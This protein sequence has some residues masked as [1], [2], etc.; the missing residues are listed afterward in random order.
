LA[1][2][3]KQDWRSRSQ[4]R[5][6]R[7]LS[8][9]LPFF[10][11]GLIGSSQVS[12]IEPKTI[13]ESPENR[14]NSRRGLIRIPNLPRSQ[15]PTQLIAKVLSSEGGRSLRAAVRY[16]IWDE[17][18][19][20]VSRRILRPDQKPAA[21]SGHGQSFRS[22]IVLLDSNQRYLVRTQLSI[23]KADQRH[24]RGWQLQL[25]QDPNKPSDRWLK[26]LELITFPALA[27]S[28]LGLVMV[29]GPRLIH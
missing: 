14:E 6:L 3:D 25:I 9:A 16:E 27:V 4:A 17:Q 5:G 19:D 29:F 22:S 20:L 24:F 2:G 13:W 23:H 21:S 7:V 26:S 11:I 15:V 12:R 28:L 10:I 18:K 1:D 8:F